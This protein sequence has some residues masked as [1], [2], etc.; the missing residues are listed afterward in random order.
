MSFVLG[1]NVPWLQCGHDFGPRPPKW[2]GTPRT[3]WRAFETDLR[4]LR[5]LGLKVARFWVLAGGVNIVPGQRTDTWARRVRFVEPWPRP[6]RWLERWR[7][8]GP[9]RWEW[10]RTPTLP[11]SFLDDFRAIFEAA[12]AADMQLVPSLVSF[13]FFF[14]IRQSSDGVPD[15]GHIALAQRRD[16]FDHYLE[17]L[18][19]I[20]ESHRPVLAAFEVMNEPDWVVRP[21]YR[22]GPYGAHPPWWGAAPMARWLVDGVRRI[23]RRGMRATIGFADGAAAWVPGHERGALVRYARAGRYVH[24]HHHYP[25]A[26]SSRLPAASSSPI[27]PCWVGEMATARAEPWRDPEAE[28]D[29]PRFLE[30]RLRVVRARGYRGA[31]VWSCHAADA[32]T[33]WSPAVIAQLRR[34]AAER[35]A[36]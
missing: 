17:P 31:L 3:D 6:R 36:G 8:G 22:N 25:R 23:A 30:A 11:V 16:F 24:Q 19:D 4:R 29:S 10:D 21:G 26:D 2:A 9:R 27:E 32:Q 35:S 28:E 34:V 33:D 5:G 15:Q 1:V 18:L 20:A 14:P 13:E 12:D 7:P